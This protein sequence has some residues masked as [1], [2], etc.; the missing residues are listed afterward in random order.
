VQDVVS[1]RSGAALVPHGR[2]RWRR[3]L[4][5]ICQIRHEEA[6]AFAPLP[7]LRERHALTRPAGGL[8]AVLDA[9]Q[10]QR[11]F[12]AWVGSLAKPGPD[13]VAIDGKTLR[14]AIKRVGPRRR[15][16]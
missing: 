12:V 15:S 9:E 3:E 10:F 11:C 13:I 1:T 14:R 8:F 7:V 5:G 6:R 2:P 4:G 16:I